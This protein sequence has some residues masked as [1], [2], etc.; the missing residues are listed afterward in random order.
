MDDLFQQTARKAL[1]DYQEQGIVDLRTILMSGKRRPI[2]QLPTGGGKTL[3][4]ASIVKG[5]RDKGKRVA[6][7]VPALSL[8]NQTV[9]AFRA[10]GITGIGVLQANHPMTDLNAPVQIATV[11]T[12]ANREELPEFDFGIVDEAHIR[13][14]ALEAAMKANPSKIFV[15][16]SATPWSK[17]LGRVYDSLVVVSTISELIGRGYLCPFR[18]YAPSTADLS[19]VKTV[20]GEFHA[21]QA[22]DAMGKITGSV[23]ESWLKFGEGR[24][25]L[26][27]GVDRRHAAEMQ[28]EFDRVGIR[29]G[30]VDAFT[31][32]VER[33]QIRRKFEDEEIKIVFNCRTLTTGVDWAVGCIIDAAPTKSDMLHVQKIGRGLRVNPGI[34]DCIILDHAGNSTRLGLVTDIHHECLDLSDKK[35]GVKSSAERPVVLPKKCVCGYLKPSGVHACPACG[36]APVA[37]SGVVVEAGDL[38]PLGKAKV[39]VPTKAEKQAF[40]SMAL[41]VDAERGKGGKLAK[42]LYRGKF[43]V[44]PVGLDAVLAVPNE[45]FRGYVKHRQIAYAKSRAKFE[46]ARHA[47]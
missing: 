4:A 31:D 1:R 29:T 24:Q 17:G 28:A 30:Y 37:R 12:F 13:N 8:V 38:V 9:A 39:H 46:G 14:T 35:K 2:L 41:S 33:D 47:V 16:L 43:G 5:A 27:F 11:Q 45:V 44:W 21:G 6:F 23:L 20:A 36:F 40:W 22:S 34:D 26:A 15:G 7:F 10:E 3:V 42:A 32:I 19:K 25:T 18:A